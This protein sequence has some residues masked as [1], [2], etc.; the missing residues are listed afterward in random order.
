MEI[1]RILPLMNRQQVNYRRALIQHLECLHGAGVQQLKRPTTLSGDQLLPGM[2]AGQ[3][4][5]VAPMEMDPKGALAVQD[6]ADSRLHL[7]AVAGGG[8]HTDETAA[9]RVDAPRVSR[10]S[11]LELLRQEVGQ[12]DRCSEIARARTQ[13]VFGTGNPDARLC[14]LGEAPGAEEDRLGEPFVGPAGELLNKILNACQLRREEVY[15]LNIL[16]CRPPGNRNPTPEEAS[17]CRSFLERQLQLIQP[18]FICC[19]GRV[20]AQNLLATT[21]PV[22]LLRGKVHHYRDIRVVCTYHPAYLLRTPAAKGKTWQD[23]KLLMRQ[24][25][26]EPE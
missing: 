6:R 4:A 9:D 25:G 20:A 19:M 18:E 2:A 14:I 7:A 26:V 22:G 1:E 5:T 13:T 15:I 10:V 12:C 11:P 23:M 3:A 16:K 17:A 24:M 21:A 8:A